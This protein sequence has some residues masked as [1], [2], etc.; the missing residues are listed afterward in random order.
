MNVLGI[1]LSHDTGVCLLTDGKLEYAINEERIS[2]VKLD[3]QFPHLAIEQLFKDCAIEPSDIDHVAWCHS[4]V[5]PVPSLLKQMG[6]PPFRHP[7]MVRASKLLHSAIYPLV[8]GLESLDR[9]KN[10]RIVRRILRKRYDIDSDVSRQ[11]HHMSHA[12][13]AYY[14]SGFNGDD[15]IVVTS[16]NAG[17]LLSAS[18]NVVDNQ[19]LRR[20]ASV[21]MDASLGFVY[22]MVTSTLGFRPLRHEGKITGLA[23]Y[24]DSEVLLDTF[25]SLFE[26]D[27]EASTYRVSKATY[28]AYQDNATAPQRL[29]LLYERF[30]STPADWPL[31]KGRDALFYQI[32][33]IKGHRREDVAAAVQLFTEDAVVRWIDSF[34]RRFRPGKQCRV[35]LAGGLFANVKVNQRVRQISGIDDVFI[36]PHMGDGGLAVG[37][38]FQYLAETGN[39]MAPRRLSHC[40]L[41]TEYTESEMEHAIRSAGLAFRRCNNVE[42]EI[43]ELLANGKV[44]ARFVGRME[45]GPRALCNRT[46]YSA[47]IDPEINTWLNER[48][49]RTEFMPFAPVLCKEDATEYL[50]DFDPE[51]SLTAEFMTI[52]YSVTQRFKSESPAAVHVDGTARPQIVTRE[53]NASAYDVLKA[54]KRITGLSV[55]INTSFNMHE[56]P[57]V[58]S[59]EDAIKGFLGGRLDA[60]ALGPFMVQAESDSSR[61][62]PP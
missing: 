11:D 18:I 13:S 14:T 25:R 55:L 30:L 23:A 9:L 20:V 5:M 53:T 43:A 27:D 34:L 61:I 6:I 7:K 41:G 50:V 56:E 37:A 39:A 46:I 2:R 58:H 24:G 60:V 59:A 48:L 51:R 57:I 26:F 28:R 54:Y 62:P 21:G 29:G 33:S 4:G 49:G 8:P 32:R 10:N 40:Y 12:A 47:A 36:H 42:E 31:L 38:A 1:N 44:V 3:T 22:S 15:V 19:T 17:D 45:Y 52:T 16:D 35:A